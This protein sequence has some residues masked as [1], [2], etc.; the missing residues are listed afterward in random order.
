[1]KTLRTSSFITIAIVALALLVAAPIAI[2]DDI[3]TGS[4]SLTTTDFSGLPISVAQFDPSLGTLNSITITLTGDNLA[5]TTVHNPTGAEIV[6]E[7]DEQTQLTLT[8]SLAGVGTLAETLTYSYPSVDVLAG[9]TNNLG[10]NSFNG[11][12]ASESVASADFAQF[13]GLGD[14]NFLI[15]S[16]S[17]YTALGGGNN[18]QIT[19]SNQDD[20][21]VTIDYNYG[22]LPPPGV[23]E[24]GTMSLFGTGLLGLAGM[25][26]S[27]FSKS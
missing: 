10:P 20:A 19:I 13:E 11:T 5:S 25:L 8:N 24:P 12:A 14:V 1:M 6:F 18:A 9:G 15:G 2:A 16:L 23:P 7:L 21:T 3:Q 27:R 17:G 4:I 26:R 22:E